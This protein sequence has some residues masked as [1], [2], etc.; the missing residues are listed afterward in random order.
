MPQQRYANHFE[1][2]SF[3]CHLIELAQAQWGK[4][5]NKAVFRLRTMPFV[6]PRLTPDLPKRPKNI[7][8]VAI[9][10]LDL[11]STFDDAES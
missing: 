1:T 8:A 10:S 4:S 6:T 3:L 9:E 7:K 11:L 2:A 5:G